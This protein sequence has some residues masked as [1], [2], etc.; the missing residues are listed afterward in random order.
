MS[1][2]YLSKFGAFIQAGR[3]VD[4]QR[5]RQM[6]ETEHPLLVDHTQNQLQLQGCAKL[7]IETACL[8]NRITAIEPVARHHPW[9]AQQVVQVEIRSQYRR[10]HVVIFLHHRVA[11]HRPTIGIAKQLQSRDQ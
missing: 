10:Q 3:L 9:K 5:F 11:E 7:R 8:G 1:G 4:H 2:Q 6:P